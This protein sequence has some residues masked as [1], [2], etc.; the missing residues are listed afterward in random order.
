MLSTTRRE[1]VKSGLA[2]SALAAAGPMALARRVADGPASPMS[3]LILGGTGF[4]GP[5]LTHHALAR[6][7]RVTLFNR[8]RTEARRREIHAP[9]EIPEGVEVLIGNRDPDKTADAWKP[10]DQRD[11]ASPKGLAALEGRS[12]DAVFDT[13]GYFPR[14]V[15]A[16]ATMLAPRVKHYTFISSVSVYKDTSRIGADETAETGTL[17]E[18]T[19]EEFGSQF[20]NYGPF[21]AMCEAAAEKAMPGR[22]ANV[23][24]GFIVGPGDSSGR[25]VQWPARAAQGGEMLAPGTPD[26]PLQ[27]MDVR[28]LAEWCV[29]LAERRVAG[30]FDALGPA[31]P[32]KWG[33]VLGACN[34]AGGDK[35]TLVWVPSEFVEAEGLQPGAQLPIWIP[36]KGESAGFHQRNP[37]KAIKAGLKF[38]GIEDTC[39]ATLEWYQSLD[40]STQFGRPKNLTPEKEAEVL[41]KWK[42]SRSGK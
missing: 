15:A 33:D 26:D 30:A 5:W 17:P 42:A 13:S 8:G 40:A 10:A 21:K 11:P 25:F 41:A 38:R 2:L 16:S 14:I 23:R 37:A 31:T 19:P 32:W 18:G 9:V 1:F 36:P 34:K 22:V 7:H 39:R 12:W 6:G 27:L 29:S 20:E 28:D 35:A 24:P 4:L 3:V